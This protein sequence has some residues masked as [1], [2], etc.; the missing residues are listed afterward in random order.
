ME[1]AQ[2]IGGD[3]LDDGAAGAAHLHGDQT[4][5]LQ[6]PQRLPDHVAA[7][8]ELLR[9]DPLR[10][11]P[12]PGLQPSVGDL[13]INLVVDHFGG[14]LG[15]SGEECLFQVQCRRAFFVNLPII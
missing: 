6:H 14:S 2:Q 15:L 3:L 8:L 12:V 4:V 1:R 13:L 9:Q 10:G 11:E 7:A 5:L